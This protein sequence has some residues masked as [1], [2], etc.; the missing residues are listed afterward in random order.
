MYH[1]HKFKQD[2]ESSSTEKRWNKVAKI[3]GIQSE[4]VN[5]IDI[6]A[7]VKGFLWNVSNKGVVA[8]PFM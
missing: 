3:S 6:L 5:S 8:Q 7:T 1:L 4:M 2:F